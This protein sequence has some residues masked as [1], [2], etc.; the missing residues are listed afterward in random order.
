MTFSPRT[1]SSSR[2]IA[3]KWRFSE[4]TRSEFLTLTA[5]R[6]GT[7]MPSDRNWARSS[8]RPPFRS[9]GEHWMFHTRRSEDGTG[10]A[11]SSTSIWY[12]SSWTSTSYWRWPLDNRRAWTGSGSCTSG[13]RTSRTSSATFAADGKANRTRSTYSGRCSREPTFLTCTFT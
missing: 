5:A 9:Y 10:A 8:R 1:G 2:R 3:G 7:G 4:S 11:T 6:Y 13:R 12:A